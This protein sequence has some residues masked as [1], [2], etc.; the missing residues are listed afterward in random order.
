MKCWPVQDAKAR[1][2]QLL[3]AAEK[4]PQ[5]IT[6][7]GGPAVVL[8]SEKEYRRLCGETE[9]ARKSFVDWWKSGPRVPEFRL[10]QRKR[11]KPRKLDL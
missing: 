7:R 11:G 6:R 9:Y 10:P 8:L 5:W 1:F 2:S 4:E 3:R